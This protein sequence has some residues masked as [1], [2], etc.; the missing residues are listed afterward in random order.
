VY[1]Q[2]SRFEL[3]IC[4]LL[5]ILPYLGMIRMILMYRVTLQSILK[6]LIIENRFKSPQ[7]NTVGKV[8]H[9]HR[10]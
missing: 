1:H 10:D 7:V 6:D 3:C 4:A 5:T 8:K 2:C 9:F